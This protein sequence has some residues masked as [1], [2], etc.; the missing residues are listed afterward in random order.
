MTGVQTCALPISAFLNFRY[1][2]HARRALIIVSDGGD[3][4][5]RA[6]QVDIRQ[7]AREADVEV[8]ALG[9]YETPGVRRRT[10][11]ELGG[12]ELLARISEETGGRSFPVQNTADIM[13]AAIRI[14]FDLRNQYLIEYHPVNQNWN[15]MYR[16]IAVEVA[17]LS[18]FPRLRANWRQ[19][20]YGATQPCVAPAS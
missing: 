6:T 8:F 5:S 18:G 4:H 12:P 11:E 16:R 7:M 19:G 9:T 1:A 20:Y 2:H 3:N 14:G 13:D 10:G 17:P 15:G